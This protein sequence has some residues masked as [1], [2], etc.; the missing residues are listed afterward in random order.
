MTKPVRLTIDAGGY[1]F[2]LFQEIYGEVVGEGREPN[3][4]EYIIFRDQETEKKILRKKIAN[5]T[6]DVLITPQ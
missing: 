3:G 6:S 1:F 2:C 4:E 5:I